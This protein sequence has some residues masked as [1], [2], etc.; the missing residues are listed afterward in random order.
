M[1]VF[2]VKFML[3]S[4]PI[5]KMVYGGGYLLREALAYHTGM[6]TNLPLTYLPISPFD[7]ELLLD[8]RAR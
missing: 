8:I 1:I 2:T 5:C 6:T 3:Y 4:S 7:L